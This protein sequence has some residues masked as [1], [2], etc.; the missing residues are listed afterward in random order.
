[1]E[2]FQE[3]F[4]IPQEVFS[5]HNLFRRGHTFWLLN[6]DNRLPAL[7]SLRVESVGLP[8]LRWVKIHLKPTSAALQLYGVHADKNVV[9]LQTSQLKELIEHK[10]IK[11]EFPA[12]FGY[13]ILATEDVII[14]CALYLPGRL[15]SQIPRHLFTS[16][17]WEHLWAD[18]KD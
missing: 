9:S 6:K 7:A 11:G 4:G 8:L 16:Q 14:G 13:V 18:K 5:N 2:V 15:I 12:S 3:R 1:L 17:T 10:E